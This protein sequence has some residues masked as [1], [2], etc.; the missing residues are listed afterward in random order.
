[1][2]LLV[3]FA[4][5]KRQKFDESLPLKLGSYKTASVGRVFQVDQRVFNFPL[6]FGD[7]ENRYLM[8]NIFVMK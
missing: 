5:K 1:V 3:I 4:N 2:Q 6:I 8:A 7:F